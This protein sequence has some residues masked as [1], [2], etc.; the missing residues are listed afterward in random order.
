MPKGARF[1]VFYGR[2]GPCLAIAGAVSLAFAVTPLPG[3][4]APFFSHHVPTAQTAIVP[5]ASPRP[6][7]N[8]ARAV[9]TERTPQPAGAATPA[10]PLLAGSPFPRAHPRRSGGAGEAPI[11][12]SAY[13]PTDGP[14]SSL[15]QAAEAA[16]DG[17]APGTPSPSAP[18]VASIAPAPSSSEMPALATHGRADSTAFDGHGTKRG[19]LKAA[20]DALK[21]D[22]YREAIERRNGL[23]DPLDQLIVDFFLVRAAPKQLTYAMVSDFASR[24]A[25]W[26]SPTLLRSRAEITL[27]RENAAPDRTIAALGGKAQTPAGARLLAK[28]YGAKGDQARATALV[29][30]I[31]HHKAMGTGLQEGY[32]R[33]F[34]SVLSAEDHLTRADRLIGDNKLSEAKALRKRLGKGPRAYLDARLAAASGAK[35]ASRK[36]KAVPRSFRRRPGYILAQVEIK[37]RADDFNGAARLIEGVPAKSVVNGDAW[38]VETRIVARSLAE[39]GKWR[40]A[41]KLAARGYAQDRK[42]RADEAFHAGW[43]ALTG[44]RDG[45]AAR[46]HFSVLK[47]VATTPLTLSR[48]SYWLGKAAERRGDSSAARRHFADAAEYGFTYYGQLA[49]MEIGRGGTGVARAPRP[50]TSDQAAMR[51]N[52]VAEAIR[53]LT[54][55]GHEH[56][57]WPLMKHLAKTVPTPGQATLVA[58]LGEKAGAPHLALMAAKEAQRRGLR[59]GQLAYPTKHIPRSA[60]IP[61]EVDKAVVFAIARQESLFN[62]GARSP[63][64]AAGLMQVMPRTG[65]AMARELGLRHST[66]KLTSDPAH[67]TTLGAAYLKKRLGNFDGSYIL[68][69]AAYNAGAGRVYEWIE[70]FGDPRRPDVDPIKWVEQI[71]FP[72]TRNYVMRVMEN[73]QVYREALGSGRLAIESD[74]HRGRPS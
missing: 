17:A 15:F 34:A 59:V 58:E 4:A 5:V 60:K 24:A 35:G 44:L 18:V 10:P 8:P 52:P 50:T 41:Y 70:R 56:R 36:L 69:F 73:V 39:R 27:A 31:W 48:G 63:V 22:R 72:E 51:R 12:P 53:R 3:S 30:S 43:L 42:E 32:L 16:A 2:R 62:A 46:T 68:T 66:K 71:P 40:R 67:N 25:G 64:G 1:K 26:P 20:L 37:R 33:D 47:G 65:A 38:W 55:A 6:K 29:R 9:S 7:P 11:N 57:I 14:V 23:K 28:A 54:A 19:S 45:K 74:L 61:S 21:R 49:R 13:A